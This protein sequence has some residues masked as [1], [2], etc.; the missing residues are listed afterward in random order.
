MHC[1]LLA[2]TLG[3]LCQSCRRQSQNGKDGDTEGGRILI[4][5]C[6]YTHR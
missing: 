6:G 3:A 1:P 2:L 5:R 4:E